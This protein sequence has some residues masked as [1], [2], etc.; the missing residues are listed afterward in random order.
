LTVDVV[1]MEGRR[2]PS[3]LIPETPPSVS[4]C[5]HEVA[6]RWDAVPVGGSLELVWGEPP[7]I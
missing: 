1:V 7:G 3:S 2:R 4:E 5:L 6:A